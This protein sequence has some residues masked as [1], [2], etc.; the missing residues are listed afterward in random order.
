[1]FS[2]PPETL[3][4]YKLWAERSSNLFYIDTEFVTEP[5]SGRKIPLEICI[6]NSLG[7]EILNTTINH[8]CS[9]RTL[10][11]LPESTPK[12]QG[13]IL[14]VY[15]K[16][17]EKITP[18]KTFDEIATILENSG[19][20]PRSYMIEW[21]M[22]FCDYS[23]LEIALQ[24]AEK[25]NLLPPRS[26]VLRLNFAWRAVLPPLPIS[27]KQGH[28]HRVI[29]PDDVEL[30]QKAHRAL[31]DVEMLRNLTRAL[32]QGHTTMA[33]PRTISSYMNLINPT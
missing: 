31:P 24:S 8:G 5:R 25:N 9:I 29:F 28:L 33:K 23:M 17:S 18:G 32:F 26:Q 19:F 11:T 7:Q 2:L 14:K 16:S 15:G 22:N 3:P 27:Y 1:L 12:Y 21:S 10:Y 20:G 4:Y 6:Y 13:I 30:P